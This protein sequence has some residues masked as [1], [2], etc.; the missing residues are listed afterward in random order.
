MNQKVIIYKGLP[1]SGKTT[2]ARKVQEDN[3]GQYVRVNKDDLRAMMFNG[4]HSWAREHVVKNVRDTIINEALHSGYSVIVDDTNLNPDHPERIKNL[5]N[6]I[7]YFRGS[8]ISVKEDTSF[9]SVPLE[10]CI[11]RD[12]KRGEKV[13]EKVIVGMW[14]K[15]L[16]DEE[17]GS[18]G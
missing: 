1:G 16:W 17:K 13:G 5:V 11:K 7:N 12:L 8:E 10:E 18:H 9:L 3:P 6:K 2:A 14:N 4:K 15:Y